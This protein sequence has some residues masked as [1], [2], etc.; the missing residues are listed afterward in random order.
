MSERRHT[1]QVLECTNKIAEE[2]IEYE[3][4]V[5]FCWEAVKRVDAPWIN[6]AGR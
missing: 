6:C 4:D 1:F 5:R 2:D 3:D